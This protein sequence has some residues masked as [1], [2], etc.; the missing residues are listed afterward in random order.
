MNYPTSPSFR[1]LRNSFI[2]KIENN[3]NNH[4][5]N[6]NND[7]GGDHNCNNNN[8]NNN[9]N[10]NGDENININNTMKSPDEGEREKIV[11]QIIDMNQKLLH[12]LYEIINVI[13]LISTSI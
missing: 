10:N 6:T 4:D 12:E 7:N 3:N 13:M 5:D 8:N 1:I 11:S 2:S 9:T